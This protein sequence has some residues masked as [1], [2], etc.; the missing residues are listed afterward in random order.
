VIPHVPDSDAFKAHSF[1]EFLSA[2]VQLAS[3]P[4][5]SV[6]GL[7]LFLPS[8]LFCLRVLADRPPLSDPRWFNVAALGWLLGQMLALALGRAQF[9]LQS[10]YT[11]M[12]LIG[13]AI[14]L[15]SAFWL[16]QS[17][18]AQRRRVVWRSA[19]LAA[20]LFLFVLSLTHPQRHLRGFINERRQIA[21]T[22]GMNLRG[23]LAT[24][25]ASF[26]GGAPA[27]EI[28]YFDRG[29]LRELLDTPEIRSALPPELLSRGPPRQWVETAKGIFL[30]LGFVWLGLGVLLLIAVSVWEALAPAALRA[31][32]G[33]RDDSS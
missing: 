31:H 30:H 5:H 3:W 19:A 23:Y 4:A 28:P 25:D 18:S 33:A 15:V 11:D 7:I 27:L 10:R 12:L 1:G 26:L 17:S 14:N 9:A 20:W 32:M 13:L 2:F 24:G 22:E 21:E 29:R 16:F 6:L 8:A